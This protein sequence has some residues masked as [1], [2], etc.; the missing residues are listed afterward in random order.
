MTTVWTFGAIV[1]NAGKIFRPKKTGLAE[2]GT[3]E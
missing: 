1:G 2:P 3:V